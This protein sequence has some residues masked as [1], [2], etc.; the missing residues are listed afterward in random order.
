MMVRGRKY[1]FNANLNVKNISKH[2]QFVWYDKCGRELCE[3][4]KMAV[5]GG[6]TL[7]TSLLYTIIKIS[8]GIGNNY[9][10][11]LNKPCP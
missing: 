5:D 11:D 9:G 7:L 10:S 1:C 3:R 2:L 4:T 8:V 6:G